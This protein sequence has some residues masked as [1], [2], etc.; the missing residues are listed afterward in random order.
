MCRTLSIEPDGSVFARGDQSK[1]DVY[2]VVLELAPKG[3]HGHPSR[4]DSRRPPAQPG[5]RA[6]VLRGAVRRLLPERDQPVSRRQAGPVQRGDGQQPQSTQGSSRRHRRR[7]ADGL[8]DQRRARVTSSRRCF[9][10]ATPLQ[11]T[12]EITVTMVFERYYAAG[13]GRFRISA[14]TDPRPIVAQ[15]RFRSTSNRFC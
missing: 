9:R 14:T 2:T 8:V 6:G 12:G 10:L 7:P 5:A 1:R 13:L 11:T 15:P 3:D 4:S